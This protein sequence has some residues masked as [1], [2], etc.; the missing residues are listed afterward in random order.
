MYI[1]YYDGSEELYNRQSDTEEWNNFAHLV[2]HQKIK[3]ELAE[4]LPEVNK[5]IH[6]KVKIGPKLSEGIIV[7][8]GSGVT[9]F[10][11]YVKQKVCVFPL[12][13]SRPR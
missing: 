7:H 3:S 10:S 13:I 1:H 11:L 5:P 2:A 4:Y 8:L 9:G 12:W 6:I